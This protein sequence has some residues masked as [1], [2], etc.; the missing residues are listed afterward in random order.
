MIQIDDAGSIDIGD[1]HTSN[2]SRHEKPTPDLISTMIPKYRPH[3]CAW[4]GNRP[5]H[6]LDCQVHEKTEY[7]RS[8]RCSAETG[9][10][11]PDVLCIPQRI[12][13]VGDARRWIEPMLFV[14]NLG[15]EQTHCWSSDPASSEYC[16]KYCGGYKTNT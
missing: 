15:E 11:P 6:P 13:G 7:R 2:Q 16:E 12:E 3:T 1:Y 4:L 9:K 10:H 8:A 5:S 14:S